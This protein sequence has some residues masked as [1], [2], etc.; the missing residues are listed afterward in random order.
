MRARVTL[1][2]AAVALTMA[3]SADAR[4]T[5]ATDPHLRPAEP[6][7]ATLVAAALE[8]SATIRDLAAQ[9]AGTDV[10]AYVRT[11]PRRDGERD[12]SIHLVGRSRHQRFLVI[13]IDEALPRARQIALIGH[14]LQHALDVAPTSWV[15]D[16]LRMQQYLELTGMR[17]LA[18][19]GFETLSAMQ[20]E[21]RVAKELQAVAV[22]AAG[23]PNPR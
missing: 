4:G 21:R 22:A 16:H 15:T 19:K 13:R 14:E 11:S 6:A 8:Q 1:V 7:A 17:S 23:R 5:A 9:L 18:E 12:A 2:A 3:A 20:A 10:V